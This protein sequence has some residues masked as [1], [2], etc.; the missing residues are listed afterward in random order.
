LYGNKY[1]GEIINNDF[2]FNPLTIKKINTAVSQT[3]SSAAA[4]QVTLNVVNSTFSQTPGCTLT[5]VSSYAINSL[6]LTPQAFSFTL[7]TNDCVVSGL[8]EIEHAQKL[9]KLFPNPTHSELI[10]DK[11]QYEK[12]II[13]DAF[14][15]IV[16]EQ[17]EFTQKINVEH[18]SKGF[19][20][21]KL[22]S[23]SLSYT[24]KFLKE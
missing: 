7:I 11:V 22:R 6:S 4:C 23:G 3:C 8:D 13:Y 9:I 20:L 2:P 18:L 5:P 10:I 17:N 21:L 15:K 1:F 14:G 12:A 16:L 24:S 19:Y